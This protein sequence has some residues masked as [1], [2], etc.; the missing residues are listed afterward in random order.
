V[1]SREEGTAV[2]EKLNSVVEQFLHGSLDYLG[3]VPQDAALERSVRAQ[4]P[5]SLNAPNSPSARAFE[6]LAGNLLNGTDREVQVR[7]GIAQMFS[8]FLLKKK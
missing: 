1:L 2:Y 8:S 4:K 6:T 5:V 7:W 3:M